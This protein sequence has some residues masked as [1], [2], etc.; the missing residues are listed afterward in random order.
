MSFLMLI[1]RK[2]VERHLQKNPCSKYLSSEDRAKMDEHLLS[3]LQYLLLQL[4]EK[5]FGE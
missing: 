5:A 1:S 3:L 2:G 4:F